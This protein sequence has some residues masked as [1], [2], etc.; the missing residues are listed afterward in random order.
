[1]P[2]ISS[3]STQNGKVMDCQLRCIDKEREGED[4]TFAFALMWFGI[5]TPFHAGDIICRHGDP[6]DPMLLLNMQTWT[7]KRVNG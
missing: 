4:P 5:P 6:G 3:C 1:M 2:P 7:T